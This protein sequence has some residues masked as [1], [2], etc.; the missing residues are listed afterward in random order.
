MK[1]NEDK[2]NWNKE[3][4]VED[5]AEDTGSWKLDRTEGTQKTS[6]NIWR[7]FEMLETIIEDQEEELTKCKSNDILL[8]W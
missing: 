5:W 7:L 3:D 4:W 6:E 8:Q 2:R 1:I